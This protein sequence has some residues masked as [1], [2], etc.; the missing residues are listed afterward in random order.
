M[1]APTTSPDASD[2]TNNAGGSDDGNGGN[3]G[4]SLA[5]L[6]CI[7]DDDRVKPGKKDGSK[8][9]TCGWCNCFYTQQNA[10]K[11]VAHLSKTKGFHICKCLA[12]IPGNRLARYH[13]LLKHSKEKK[14]AKKRASE[15]TASCIAD[16]QEEATRDLMSKKSRRSSS[17]TIHAA[18]SSA[19]ATGAIITGGGASAGSFSFQPSI[20][21]YGKGQQITIKGS[22][23]AMLEMAIADL[24]HAE[25]LSFSLESNFFA[26]HRNSAHDGT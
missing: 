12:T 6:A 22:N 25:G 20:D 24:C 11:A 16:S 9:W 13:V 14:T 17:A 23:E 3:S 26:P 4:P 18:A 7:W 2:V 21:A 5:L 1:S 15:A 19:A 8:G 10:T